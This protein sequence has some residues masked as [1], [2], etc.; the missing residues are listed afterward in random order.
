LYS[1]AASRFDLGLAMG[2]NLLHAFAG[3]AQFGLRYFARFLDE[4][5]KNDDPLA[6]LRAVEHASYAFR[7]AR[8]QFEQSITHCARVRHTQIG[9]MGLHRRSESEVTG[10][11]ARGETGDLLAGC[12]AVVRNRP[13]A[14]KI[15]A[16]LRNSGKFARM[17]HCGP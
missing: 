6:N 2:L 15:L 4:R 3:N 13:H 10:K 14:A 11:D 5:V 17:R 1:S 16:N 8:A 9:T 7:P 12:F